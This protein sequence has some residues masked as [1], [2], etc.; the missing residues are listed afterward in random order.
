MKY[1]EDDFNTT[2]FT[3]SSKGVELTPEGEKVYLW[4]KET[5]DEREN[6]KNNF[7]KN[8]TVTSQIRETIEL[9]L[10]PSM[11]NNVYAKIITPFLQKEPQVQIK[12]YEEDL[13]S[14]IDLVEKNTTF[15]GTYSFK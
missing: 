11:N 13:F 8:L 6:L 1:I 4:A 14:I 9:I 7:S 12:S 2:L 3:R 15:P 10:A 5:L